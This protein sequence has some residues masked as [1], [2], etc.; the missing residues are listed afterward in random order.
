MN[1]EGRKEKRFIIFDLGMEGGRHFSFDF[2]CVR[3]GGVDTIL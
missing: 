2:V 3:L 1:T